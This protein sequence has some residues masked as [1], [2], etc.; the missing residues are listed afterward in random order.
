[1]LCSFLAS[2]GSKVRHW[3]SHNVVAASRNSAPSLSVCIF[4]DQDKWRFIFINSSP[5]ISQE[6]L[7]IDMNNKIRQFEQHKTENS[8]SLI[9][10]P[11]FKLNEYKFEEKKVYLQQVS[12]Q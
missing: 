2:F 7:P 6:N 10:Y 4:S 9:I 3:I 8:L 1:M 12:P 5:F 11:I